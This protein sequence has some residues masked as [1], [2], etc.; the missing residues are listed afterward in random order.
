VGAGG[1]SNPAYQLDIVGDINCTGALRSGG[2]S[3][4]ANLI[5][6]NSDIVSLSNVVASYCNNIMAMSN[7][8]VNKCS[9]YSVGAVALNV[10]SDPL[11]TAGMYHSMFGYSTGVIT[12]WN[13]N[14]PQMVA[15]M[16]SNTTWGFSSNMGYF[17]SPI[18]AV[19]KFSATMKQSSTA[20]SNSGFSVW[21]RTYGASASNVMLLS[22]VVA[23]PYEQ[24]SF[25]II[26]PLL[27]GE[28]IGSSPYNS[29]NQ[30]IPIYI[31]SV[32]YISPILV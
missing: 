1:Q 24:V 27:Y 26:V 20:L 2:I 14:S 32:E 9:G 6:M 5:G 23:P 4:G 31:E 10:N 11:A 15:S 8:L 21:K 28:I 19:Y 30:T 16:G 3:V 12:L 13:Y 29:L 17:Q 25:S 7:T 22:P 18:D